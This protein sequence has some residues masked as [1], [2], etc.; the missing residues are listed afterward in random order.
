MGGSEV[1]IIIALSEYPTTQF[2]TRGLLY[3]FLPSEGT[4]IRLHTDKHITK[5]N[6]IAI[7][8]TSRYWDAQAVRSLW[9][10]GQPD[11]HKEFQASQN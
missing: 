9:V 5:N 6:I 2:S 4:C 1:K 3:P 7:I 11:L 8:L 10:Q